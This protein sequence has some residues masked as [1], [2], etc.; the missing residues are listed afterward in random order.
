MCYTVK[1][2]GDKFET[3]KENAGYDLRAAEDAV[4]PARGRIKIDVNLRTSFSENLV[5]MV[6]SRSG[7]ALNFGVHVIQDPGIIDSSYRGIYGVILA[8]DSDKD[9]PVYKGNKIAQLLFVP[10]IHP[11]FVY[12]DSVEELGDSDRS[13]K[14]FGASGK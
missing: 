7:L 12:T 5:A 9:Y 10:I 4:V 2:F 3:N 8:N 13:E 1:V 11:N 14:G 6:C